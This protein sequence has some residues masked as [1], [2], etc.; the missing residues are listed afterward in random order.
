MTTNDDPYHHGDLKEA[1]VDAA[2]RVLD[3]ESV[4]AATLRRLAR[5]AGVSHAAPYHHFADLD[6]LLAV[7][8]ARGFEMLRSEMS[9]PSAPGAEGSLRRLQA[10]GTAYVR[11][12]VTRPELFRLMFSGRWRDTA[13]H[14]ALREAESRAYG[15][16]EAMIAGAGDRG[17]GRSDLGPAVRAAWALVHGIAMLVLDGRIDLPPGGGPVESAERLTREVTTVLGRGLRGTVQGLG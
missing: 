9:R 14:P 12:A 4:G 16:L 13:S 15:A 5:E 7:V 1:L 6:A 3:T 11:F 17:A 2:L 10:A 8:A